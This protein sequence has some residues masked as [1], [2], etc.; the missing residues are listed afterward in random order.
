MKEEE[1]RLR[2]SENPGFLRLK[3]SVRELV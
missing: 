2:Y 3:T 1:F